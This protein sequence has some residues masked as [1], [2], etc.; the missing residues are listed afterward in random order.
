MFSLAYNNYTSDVYEKDPFSIT[1][2]CFRSSAKSKTGSG[3][4]PVI[5]RCWFPQTLPTR[6]PSR[7]VST[8]LTPD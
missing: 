7:C 3:N 5:R 6:Q 2:C 1:D 4:F 8:D